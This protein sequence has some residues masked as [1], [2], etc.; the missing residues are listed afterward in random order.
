MQTCQRWAQN[1]VHY[2]ILIPIHFWQL[3]GSSP[4]ENFPHLN[5]PQFFLFLVKGLTKQYSCKG[6]VLTYSYWQCKY[7]AETLSMVLVYYEFQDLLRWGGGFLIKKGSHEVAC[8]CKL[9]TFRF[10][11]TK[12]PHG[13]I[14]MQ[15]RRWSL[16]WTGLWTFPWVCNMFTTGTLKENSVWLI[17]CEPSLTLKEN[18]RPWLYFKTGGANF[19]LLLFKCMNKWL[20]VCKYQSNL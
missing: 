7:L 20:Q 10:K 17:L 1:Q 5:I 9:K 3:S 16:A 15:N 12:F 13:Q 6:F 11:R 2:L 4:P 19:L 14:S 8:P 18:I